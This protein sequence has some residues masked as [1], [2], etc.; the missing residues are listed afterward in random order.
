MQ[1]VLLPEAIPC[2]LLHGR[3][4]RSPVRLRVPCVPA[5]VVRSSHIPM[6][7]WNEDVWATATLIPASVV[8]GYILYRLRRASGRQFTDTEIVS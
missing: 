5:Y 7:S 4:V 1:E 2:S 3:L 8:I 6:R